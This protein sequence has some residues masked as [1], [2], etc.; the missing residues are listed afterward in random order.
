[1]EEGI[2]YATVN[3]YVC[4][5][6]SAVEFVTTRLVLKQYGAHDLPEDWF[7]RAGQFLSA[8]EKYELCMLAFAPLL[9]Y[10]SVV[11]SCMS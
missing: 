3:V 7:L 5:S 10:Q 9:K 2:G 4:S 8:I 1:L 11:P 6:S